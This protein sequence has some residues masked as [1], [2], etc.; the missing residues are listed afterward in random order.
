M[1]PSP[2]LNATVDQE[3]YDRAC[4]ALGIEETRPTYSIHQGSRSGRPAYGDYN[5]ATNH[6]RLFLGISDYEFDALRFAQSEMVRTM[7]HELRHAYQHHHKTPVSESDAERWACDHVAEFRK[8]IRLSRSFP[9]TGFS[10]LSRHTS[11]QMV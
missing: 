2:R 5:F 1:P 4:E 11:H 8:L 9:N 10:R 6:V 7:L 3:T